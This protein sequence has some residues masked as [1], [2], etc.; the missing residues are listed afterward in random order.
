MVWLENSVFCAVRADD[1][2][3]NNGYSN[4]NDVYCSVR[5]YISRVVSE[6]K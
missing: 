6:M 1:C 3:R 5:A 2:T 4:R